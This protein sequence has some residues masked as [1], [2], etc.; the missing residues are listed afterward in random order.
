MSFVR[1]LV[2]FVNFPPPPPPTP[3]VAVLLVSFF[4]M[5][6]NLWAALVI[7][8]TVASIVLHMLG[9]MAVL[10][11][12]ANAVSLVNLV[13]VSIISKVEWLYILQSGVAPVFF[14]NSAPLV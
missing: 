10:G 9:S 8:G 7:V 6:L 12:N 13:M 4:L 3:S 1:S 14:Q 11:I 2:C 5:G